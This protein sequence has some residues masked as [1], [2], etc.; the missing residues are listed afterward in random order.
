M[1]RHLVGLPVVALLI[2]G[3]GS[4]AHATLVGDNVRYDFFLGVDNIGGT[5]LFAIVV[6]DGAPEFRT[7]LGPTTIF[8]NLNASSINFT[9]GNFTVPNP[10]F[11]TLSTGPQLSSLDWVDNPAAEIIGFG[12]ETNIGRLTNDLVSF[13]PHEIRVNLAGL[14]V[15]SRSFFDIT[16]QVSEPIPEPGTL[17]L[18][19]SGLPG[20]G[21]GTR[22]RR[23]GLN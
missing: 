22:R 12:L 6:P 4:V 17:L 10:T 9:F 14:T 13:G 15:E 1:R 23:R 18:I 7:N 11:G 16:L 2:S 8:V 3:V 19:G 5:P 20:V 21:L